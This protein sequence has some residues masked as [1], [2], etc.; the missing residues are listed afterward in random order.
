MVESGIDP[1]MKKRKRE[2][3]K[4]DFWDEGDVF[5]EAEEAEEEE[6]AEDLDDDEPEKKKRRIINPIEQERRNKKLFKI[7]DAIESS[8]DGR[9][10]RS[11]LFMILPSK[12]EYP[13]YYQIIKN[14]IDLVTIRKKVEDDY[15][16]TA[17]SF[18]EDINI[19][20]N[21]AKTYNIEASQVYADANFLQLLSRS[22]GADLFPE[23]NE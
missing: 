23:Q 22:L 7:L 5:G 6:D 19:L 1:N 10:A 9:R 14:P 11:E 15:Y 18:F 21:N 12:Q 16:D 8:F 13:D 17:A 2:E 4:E 20:F 3:I